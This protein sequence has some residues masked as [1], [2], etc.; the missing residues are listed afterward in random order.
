MTC[1]R[2]SASM[3]ARD[4][5][6]SSSSS[7]SSSIGISPPTDVMSSSLAAD[8]RALRLFSFSSAALRSASIFSGL[9]NCGA[10]LASGP[11]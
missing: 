11:E 5:L 3:A 6:D 1:G 4:R 8:M 9:W 10:A 7:S 2:S